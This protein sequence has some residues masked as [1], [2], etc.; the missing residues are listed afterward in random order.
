MEPGAVVGGKYHVVK[1]L[2]EGGMGAV[3]DAV[4]AKT[5]RR[6]AIKL[7]HERALVNAGRSALQRFEREARAAASV[8]SLHV[9]Q[10]L[11]S[12]EDEAT[13][14][15]FLVLEYLDGDDLKRVLRRGPLPEAVA[16]KIAIQIARGLVRA[17]ANDV[18]HRDLKPANVFLARVDG[19]TR[20][21]KLLDFGVAKLLGEDATRLTS[22][23]DL[24]GSPSYMSPEQVEA[25]LEVDAQ[26]DLWALGVVLHEMLTGATP[27]AH[28]A[29]L[30]RKIHAIC[31]D[32]APRLSGVSPAVAD[33]VARAL[34]VE[35]GERYASAAEMLAALEAAGPGSAEIREGELD[36]ATVT[37]VFVAP[38]KRGR[39]GW[40][41]LAA[42]VAILGAVV[43]LYP[44]GEDARRDEEPPPEVAASSV[45]AASTPVPTS[46]P[47]SIESAAVP[48]PV[49]GRRPRWRREAGAPSPPSDGRDRF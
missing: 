4:H 30:S 15:P 48:R 5:G 20:L 21:V 28:V 8:D 36:P 6:V 25:P 49:S 23:D 43:V 47:T 38:V 22:A 31:N 42:G 34:R 37:Q 3:F 33:V 1:P 7:I 17:H 24:I 39:R 35:R 44:R 12:G 14:L 41:A 9:V 40:I 10:V 46:A 2:G 19:G 18:V 27:T 26:T 45:L 32:P 29:D 16:L 11:D 13:G